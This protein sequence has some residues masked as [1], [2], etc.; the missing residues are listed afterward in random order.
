[1]RCESKA[2]PHEAMAGSRFCVNHRPDPVRPLG[3]EDTLIVKIEEIPAAH[4]NAVATDLLKAVLALQPTNAMKVRLRKFSKPNLFCTQR[5]ALA[6]GVRIGVRITGEWAYLWKLSAAEISAA[7]QK[8]D[9][10]RKA[11]EKKGKK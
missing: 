8:A 11:R 7:D 4:Q 2:C 5:Y 10:M 1:M 6:K 9:R 3:E